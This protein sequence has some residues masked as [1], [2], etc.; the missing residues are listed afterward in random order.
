M[1]ASNNE[2]LDPQNAG[3]AN[4]TP[5]S[6]NG[7]ALMVRDHE[8]N[9]LAPYGIP[10]MGQPYF[11]G[12]P[13]GLNLVRLLHALRRRW[14]LA[15]CV[16]LMLAVPAAG[17]VWLIAPTNF[18][19]AG[20]LHVG[21]PPSVASGE[22]P[23]NASEYESFRK[24]Q[25]A[26]IKSVGVLS[27]ALKTPGVADLPML[28]NRSEPIKF[29]EDEISVT[30]PMETE[31]LQ[32]RMQGKDAQQLVKIVNAVRQSY[33]DNIVNGE[34]IQKLR[35]ISL[36]ERQYKDSMDQMHQK[37]E[38][39]SRLA[40]DSHSPDL[41]EVQLQLTM[42]VQKA[43]EARA[44]VSKTNSDLA[45]VQAKIEVLKERDKDGNAPSE[46]MIESMVNRDPIL[47]NLVQKLEEVR[48][49]YDIHVRDTGNRRRD[50]KL[51]QL[52]G[53]ME[54]YQTQLDDRRKAL[55]PGI[56]QELQQAMSDGAKL[57]EL[58]SK[59]NLLGGLLRTQQTDLDAIN[60]HIEELNTNTS[61]YKNLEASIKQFRD[62]ADRLYAE[63][64]DL[65]LETDSSVQQRVTALGDVVPPEGAN[66]VMR[67]V[68]TVFAGL[69]GLVLGAGTVVGV[70][71]QA[72]RLNTSNE[73]GVD[74]GLRVLGTV[75]NLAAMSRTKGLSDAG[76]IQGVLAESVDSI[77]TILLQHSREG[78]PHVIMIT[79]AGDSEGKTTVACHLA[80]SLAR[81]GRRTLLVD[82]DLRSP[83]AH[84]VFGAAPEPGVCE[85]LRGEV[86]LAAA[87]QPTA[88]DGLMFMPGGQCDYTAV[89]SLSKKALPNLIQ[90]MRDEFEFV[91]I[92]A[93]P[94]LTY[95]DTLLLG[96][97]VDGA[98]LSVR[99]DFSRMH[100]VNEA[101]DRLDSVGIR[102]IGAV[103]NGISEH[104]RRPAY[105]LPAAV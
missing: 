95:A 102:I 5:G 73:L 61:Q 20:Y 10:A 28:V 1:N 91:V 78:A 84:L 64:Q 12:Q 34:Q 103:V 86:E 6:G 33:L 47:M 97:H 23:R 68:L 9:G 66:F 65:K 57:P 29:L 75:P 25:V 94:V 53:M 98:V 45:D 37:E 52:K 48:G 8:Q 74:A 4:G 87:L 13:A 90:K 76:V 60:K 104:S 101:R 77:R 31:L 72:R 44:Q 51:T 49:A 14:L 71:Y 81:S 43:A 67:Y 59:A 42:E 96:A 15:L 27:E 21:D 63:L 39:Q 17:L 79:S 11:D 24:T 40:R 38:M 93:G 80:A 62:S 88:V 82:G 3:P 55:R 99:R 70:E 41:K 100:K 7:H 85:V 32:I 92:D 36:I 30:A 35:R 83:T 69:A 26:L 46:H 19:V 50:P 58:Q 2:N 105:A 89:A 18:D 22:K 16:G 54:D 56:I